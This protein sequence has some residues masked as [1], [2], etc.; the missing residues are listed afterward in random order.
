M[1]MFVSVFS[2]MVLTVADSSYCQILVDY[3][4]IDY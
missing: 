1:V 4:I 3:L 2:G